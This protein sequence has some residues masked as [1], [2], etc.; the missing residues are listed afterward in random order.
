M[1]Y[2]VVL[3]GY[4]EVFCRKPYDFYGFIFQWRTKSYE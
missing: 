2:Q 3:L 1:K 4:D